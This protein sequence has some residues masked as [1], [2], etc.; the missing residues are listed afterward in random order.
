MT[1]QACDWIDFDMKN[2]HQTMAR[3]AKEEEKANMEKINEKMQEVHTAWRA[4]KF[5]FEKDKS[6]ALKAF[7]WKCQQEIEMHK[8]VMLQ[9]YM[10]PPQIIHGYVRL[11]AQ[12]INDQMTIQFGFGQDELSVAIE[13]HKLMEDKS[14]KMF[15]EMSKKQKMSEEEKFIK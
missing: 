6:E 11:E 14:F 10:T 3:F 9:K 12:K 2:F 4:E 7:Q 15:M 13:Q 8:K 1:T 5:K